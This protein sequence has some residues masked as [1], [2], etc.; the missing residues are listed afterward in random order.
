M[1]A[2]P[3]FSPGIVRLD[4]ALDALVAADAAIEK[5]AGGFTFTEGPIWFP[6][7]SLY[8]SDIPE[9]SI[10]RRTPDGEIQLFRKPSG[11][12]GNDLP[13]GAFIGSNGLTRDKEGR[14]VIC[15]H[16]N[17]RVTRLEHDGSLTVLVSHEGGK[18]LNSPNDLVYKS[19]GTLYFTDPPYGMPL[20]D[21]DPRKELPYNGIYMLKDG[22]L[23]MLY[24]KMRRPN[25]L[26]FTPDEKFLYVGNSDPKARLWNKFP[27]LEDGTLG[28]PVE[29]ANLTHL[30]EAGNPDGMKI[31]TNGNLYCTGPGGTHVFDPSG[32]RL[33]VIVTPEI[34]ANLHW[35]DA[36]AGTLYITARTG[37]Y[38]VRTKA[39]G[40]RP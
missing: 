40:I 33:G 8:F 20:Q 14:L 27:V 15:E 10:F 2:Q 35:G 18:R 19:D 17:H 25:G 38:L 34:P 31:D 23:T 22:V 7:G 5:L 30:T 28:E 9:N 6:D 21:E 1:S 16:S 32:K 24:S 13:P 39:T 36:D 37:L 12:D 29:F 26:V 11:Y 4:P 3:T